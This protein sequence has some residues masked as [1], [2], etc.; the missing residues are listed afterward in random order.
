[1]TA[2]ISRNILKGGVSTLV[3]RVQPQEEQA[4]PWETPSAVFASYDQASVPV[5]LLLF[6]F[7][8][9]AA[10]LESQSIPIELNRIGN[11][12]KS[13]T[14]VVGFSKTSKRPPSNLDR[15]IRN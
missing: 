15:G 10:Q 9:S 3:A 2:S 8:P 14:L 6:G 5:A 4:Q 1:M 13:A 11:F 7:V 12:I